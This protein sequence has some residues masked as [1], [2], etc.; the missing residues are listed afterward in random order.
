M[1][2]ETEHLIG[3]TECFLDYYENAIKYC[4]RMD[5]DV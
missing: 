5:S 1:R 2:L 4:S 3:K